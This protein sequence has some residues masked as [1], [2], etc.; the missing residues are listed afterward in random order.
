MRQLRHLRA[1]PVCHARVPLAWHT[2]GPPVHLCVATVCAQC[3]T[4][5]LPKFAPRGCHLRGTHMGHVSHM[6]A[7]LLTAT[8]HLC[9]Q[10]AAPV[11]NVCSI[12]VRIVPACARCAPLA[13]NTHVPFVPHACCPSLRHVCATCVAHTCHGSH[14]RVAPGV[15]CS[16][17]CAT[18]VLPQFVS[19]TYSTSVLPHVRRSATC[20]TCVIWRFFQFVTRKPLA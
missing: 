13:W 8:C 1:A 7:A 15:Q 18:C 9:H 12:C 17:T 6:R 4:C 20:A 2:H 3:S 16:A 5:V 10:R 14:L 11:C 19:C